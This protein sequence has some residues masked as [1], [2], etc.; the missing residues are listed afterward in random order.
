MAEGRTKTRERYLVTTFT[1]E[2]NTCPRCGAMV[3]VTDL[4]DAFHDR[5]EQERNEKPDV[6]WGQNVKWGTSE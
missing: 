5:L 1:Q 4:H 2:W 3:A 6:R